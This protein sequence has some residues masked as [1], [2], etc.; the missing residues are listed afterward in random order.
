M[1]TI[2]SVR[3]KNTKGPDRIFNHKGTFTIN[4]DLNF[5]NAQLTLSEQVAS[6]PSGPEDDKPRT[7][8][9]LT[10]ATVLADRQAELISSYPDESGQNQLY[11]FATASLIREP[12]VP[13]DRFPMLEDLTEQNKD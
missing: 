11:L 1:T 8:W 5:M 4:A 6:A 12:I 9:E 3:R 7:I 2:Q 10:T 13:Y